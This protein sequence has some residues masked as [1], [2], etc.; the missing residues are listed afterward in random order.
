[1]PTV[2]ST[3]QVEARNTVQVGKVTD[4]V[5]SQVCPSQL[6]ASLLFGSPPSLSISGLFVQ[7]LGLGAAL[8]L[9]A[10]FGGIELLWDC[11]P[12]LGLVGRELVPDRLEELV[13]LLRGI[14]LDGAKH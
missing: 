13:L 5:L 6:S 12:G 9:G 14:R 8:F 11:W 7:L 4:I 3:V 1:M 10:F 2:R